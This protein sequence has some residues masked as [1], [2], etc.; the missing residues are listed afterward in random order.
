MTD[1]QIVIVGSGALARSVGHSLAALAA[2]PAIRAVFLAR[3]VGS[4]GDL[5]RACRARAAVGGGRITFAAGSLADADA[6]LERLRPAVLLCC[7]S[8]Q[9]PYERTVA[10]SAWTALVAE[11]GFGITLPFQ[12]VIAAGLARAVSRVSPETL[13]VN[14]AFPDAV[15]PLLAVLG[16]PVLCG[17]GNVSTLDACLRAELG[18]AIRGRL[19]VLGHHVHLGRAADEVRAWVGDRPLSDVTATLAGYRALPRAELNAIAGHAAA[20]LVLD[21]AAGVE[22]RANVPGPLG[23]PGGYPVTITDGVARLDPPPGL[24]RAD[25][26]AWNLRAGE[27]DGLSISDGHVR[28]TPVA[29]AAL[30]THLPHRADGWAPTELDQMSR[31]LAA[32]RQRLRRLPAV[33]VTRAGP[34]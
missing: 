10:P 30:A 17:I 27:A 31:E 26:I 7:V 14:G 3:N 11:A 19:A 34:A 2:G 25:A 23:L 4:A 28:Y 6:V 8:E 18:S 32:I 22:V 1:R 5:A 16:L 15:N 21:L 9:S 20:R 13:F 29:A 12:A 24:T 33:P